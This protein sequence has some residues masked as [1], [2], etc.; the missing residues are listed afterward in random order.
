MIALSEKAL[1]LLID[2]SVAAVVLCSVEP[3]VNIVYYNLSKPS[4]SVLK[5]LEPNSL[6]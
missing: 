6:A 2:L 4:W 1:P 5:G 3:L